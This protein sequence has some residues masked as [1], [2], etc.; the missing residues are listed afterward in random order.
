MHSTA[1]D[2]QFIFTWQGYDPIAEKKRLADLIAETAAAELF[3]MNG[4]LV[5]LQA[6]QVVPVGKDVL[7]ETIARHVVTAQ[8]VNRGDLGWDVEFRPFEFPI[9]ADV[10]R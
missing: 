6:G 8:L 9:G 1:P 7:K 5:L 3:A 10:S 2:G 4:G